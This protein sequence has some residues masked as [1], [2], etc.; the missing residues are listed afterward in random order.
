MKL[1]QLRK[2]LRNSKPSKGPLSDELSVRTCQHCGKTASE[3]RLIWMQGE[4]FKLCDECERLQQQPEAQTTHCM[5]CDKPF[6]VT[7]HWLICGAC[8]KTVTGHPI[9]GGGT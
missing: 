4:L 3:I 6:T 1:D 2:H 9:G 5:R 7:G 8:R